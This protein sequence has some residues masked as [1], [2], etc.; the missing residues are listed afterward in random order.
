MI[1]F[2]CD[3]TLPLS[4]IKQPMEVL[5]PDM[6]LVQLGRQNYSLSSSFLIYWPSAT[7]SKH[8]E[9]ANQNYSGGWRT[10]EMNFHTPPT[11]PGFPIQ[12]THPCTQHLSQH[13]HRSANKEMVRVQQWHLGGTERGLLDLAV[14]GERGK[15]SPSV[16]FAIT[17]YWILQPNRVSLSPT[18]IL[19]SVKFGHILVLQN[20][21]FCHLDTMAL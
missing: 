1:C 12:A 21:E 11:V 13:S 4:F 7:N 17:T 8:Y 2:F 10:L 19:C 15:T 18:E 16:A 9:A 6:L 3:H 14:L 5:M 20:S